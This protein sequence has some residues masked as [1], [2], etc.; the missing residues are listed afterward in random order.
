M[1]ELSRGQSESWGCF[2]GG[3]ILWWSGQ[4]AVCANRSLGE[5][6]VHLGGQ[7]LKNRLSTKLPRVGEKGHRLKT[8]G[9]LKGYFTDLHYALYK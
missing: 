9:A 1:Q 8:P 3:F 2:L 4:W 5:F 7:V 6:P